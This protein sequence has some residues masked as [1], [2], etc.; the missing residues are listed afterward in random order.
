MWKAEEVHL[1]KGACRSAK[2]VLQAPAAYTAQLSVTLRKTLPVSKALGASLKKKWSLIKLGSLILARSWV[3]E[4]SNNRK[5]PVIE[6]LPGARTG[7]TRLPS[8]RQQSLHFLWRLTELGSQWV[9][10]ETLF[11]LSQTLLQPREACGEEEVRT[12]V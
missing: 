12:L 8:Y 10:Q 4:H 1:E 5:R 3:L 6:T 11:L 7:S 2:P 9:S